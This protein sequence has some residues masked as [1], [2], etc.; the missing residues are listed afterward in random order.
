MGQSTRSLQFWNS[1]PP[2]GAQ[3]AP[4]C[5]AVTRTPR[6][7][8]WEP[9]LHDFEHSPHGSQLPHKQST[10]QASSLQTSWMVV[11]PLHAAPFPLCG[12]STARARSLTPPPH[13]ALHSLL[14]H[15]LQAQSTSQAWRLHFNSSTGSPAHSAPP[16]ISG[17]FKRFRCVQPPP[18]CLSQSLQPPQSCHSQFT[19]HGLNGHDRVSVPS[20]RLQVMSTPP[21]AYAF[22]VLF[23]CSTVTLQRQPLHSVH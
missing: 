22:N 18:Q 13:V 9:R 7:R 14:L 16:Y 3:G 11:G 15:G 5:V 6:L 23:R 10:G 20:S 8:F 19:G 4:P 12:R 21:E 2:S 1:T 17:V